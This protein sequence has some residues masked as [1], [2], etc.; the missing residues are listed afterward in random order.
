MKLSKVK[1]PIAIVTAIDRFAAPAGS[2]ALSI[3]AHNADRNLDIVVLYKNLND[4]DICA[5]NKIPRVTPVP[6]DFQEGFAEHMLS[7]AG[8]TSKIRNKSSLMPFCHFEAFRLLDNYRRVL[9]LDADTMVQGPLDGLI[10]GSAF[11][12]TSDYPWTVSDNFLAPIEG[13]NMSSLGVCTA[14][15]GLSDTLPYK[16][17][18]S[19]CIERAMFLSNLLFNRDQGIINLALQEYAIKHSLLECNK[20]QCMPWKEEAIAANIVHF[21]SDNKPWNNENITAA[22]PGWYRYY[23]IWLKLGGLSVDTKP[24]L[25]D[26]L[27]RFNTN[28]FREHVVC[29][30]STKI[31]ERL[32][33]AENDAENQH[34]TVMKMRQRVRRLVDHRSKDSSEWILVPN[35]RIHSLKQ[36]LLHDAEEALNVFSSMRTDN[37]QVAVVLGG[38]LGDALK[39]TTIFPHLVKKLGCDLTLIS[40]QKATHDLRALNPYIVNALVSMRNPYEFAEE[41]LQHSG[42]YDAI[43][44]YRYTLKYIISSSSRIPEQMLCSIL[45]KS[46]VSADPYKKYNFS[47]RVWP[48]LN[49]AFSRE[50]QKNNKGVLQT[51]AS[52]SGI[53]I[54]ENEAFTIP[55]FLHT[56]SDDSLI[57]FLECP[58]I[59][60]HHGFDVK[61]L[62][63]V[64][65][66]TNCGSTKNLTKEKWVEIVKQLRMLGLRVV[67]L[68][69]AN[70]E[71][72]DGVD[73][74]LNG[75]TTL[76]QTANI[77]KWSLCHVDTE[78]GLVHLNRSVHGRSVVM[79]GPTPVKTFGYPQNINLSPSACKEC[80]WT[81]QSWVL[82]CPRNTEGPE[83]MQIYDPARVAATVAQLIANTNTTGATLLEVSSKSNLSELPEFVQLVLGISESNTHSNLVVCDF[84]ILNDIRKQL[85]GVE[86]HFSYAVTGMIDDSAKLTQMYKHTRVGS[87]LNLNIENESLDSVICITPNWNSVNAPF[88]LSEM[89]RVLKPNGLLLALC[90]E[91]AEEITEIQALF[92]DYRIEMLTKEEQLTPIRSF[93]LSKSII[94]R[95]PVTM[96]VSYTIPYNSIS[97]STSDNMPNNLSNLHDSANKRLEEA[98]RYHD[99]IIANQNEAWALSDELI[100]HDVLTDG[101]ISV[102]SESV[103]RYGPKF[104]LKGWF[105]SEEWG[106]WGKGCKHTIL[107]PLP[108]LNHTRNCLVFEAL[109]DLRI[110]PDLPERKIGVAVN[111]SNPVSIVATDNLDGDPL[112]MKFVIS[113][114][115][116]LKGSFITLD[117][118]VDPPF[119]PSV[120]MEDKEDHRL[121]G[122]GLRKFR[123]KVGDGAILAPSIEQSKLSLQQLTKSSVKKSIKTAKIIDFLKKSM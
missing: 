2:L 105:E 17:I 14:V 48:S 67:Q 40:D 83:C 34:R 113:Y 25:S 120:M 44:I 107:L 90:P 53:D 30:E 41:Y 12:V 9:W 74:C 97:L 77:L 57:P 15:M 123:Y 8:A 114:K 85:E 122:I 39:V 111:G 109:I 116:P 91:P 70:E 37:P 49:N 31:D 99:M 68:G 92:R 43:L 22:W 54:S 98:L 23:K 104:L 117:I 119:I 18:Y 51:L 59:T 63:A 27:K 52:S 64:N 82:E 94:N 69:A 102:S 45:E 58:Y 24:G 33:S 89:L 62:P 61:K 101:W 35:R 73:I 55:L 5:L 56:L 108:T 81:T 7:T 66:K 65:K 78:G 19:W 36:S 50:M 46:N 20:W 16:K 80:F 21:G 121:L 4:T 79:F 93:I 87:F 112:L 72:I 13:Y 42:I 71:E 32:K 26:G 6:F 96:P 110:G 28:A 75:K 10:N 29:L 3:N 88:I 1:K 84:E 60:V 86:D 38:G 103:E 100:S 106:C 118:H 76:E 47:N 115:Y 11:T 95:C